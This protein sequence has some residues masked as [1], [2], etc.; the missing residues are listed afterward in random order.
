MKYFLIIAAIVTL[1]IAPLTSTAFAADVGMSINIGQPNFYGR[2]DPNGYP[3]PRVIYRQPKAIGQ[4]PMN[5]PPVYMRVPPGQARNWKKNC[6]R[7]NAC[8]ERVLFVQDK[9]YRRDYA[10]RYQQQNGGRGQPQNINNDG[11]GRDR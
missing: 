5:Q 3:Q 6:G 4:V 11:Y 9:W 2:L 8:D 10:P 7:Y 1:T